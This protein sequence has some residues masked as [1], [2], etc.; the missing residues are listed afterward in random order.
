MAIKIRRGDMV[1]VISGDDKGRTGRVLSVDTVKMRVV[2]E[3]VNFVKR[4]TKPKRQGVQGGILEK[5]AP[6]HISK[7]QLFDPKEGRGVRVGMRVLAD[8]SRERISRV[9]GE[10]LPKPEKR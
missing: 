9:S 6:L 7:V 5:E 4:H 2:V 8:G 1:Q 10:V 3:K